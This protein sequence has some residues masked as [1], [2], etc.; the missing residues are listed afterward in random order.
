MQES[1]LLRRWSELPPRRGPVPALSRGRDDAGEPERRVVVLPSLQRGQSCSPSSCFSILGGKADNREPAFTH[2]SNHPHGP[3]R[4]L[5][6]RFPN[7]PMWRGGRTSEGK[8]TPDAGRAGD[9][10]STTCANA[11]RLAPV[12]TEAAFHST[13]ERMTWASTA[14]ISR[15]A[16]ASRGRRTY[17]FVLPRRRKIRP[18]PSRGLLRGAAADRPTLL[19]SLGRVRRVA[20]GEASGIVAGSSLARRCGVWALEAKRRAN[21]PASGRREAHPEAESPDLSGGPCPARGRCAGRPSELREVPP[22]RQLRS[23]SD[24]SSRPA[25]A[26][27]PALASSQARSDAGTLK[28]AFEGRLAR[29]A[30]SRATTSTDLLKAIAKQ[31]FRHSPPR[32]LKG[33]VQEDRGLLEAGPADTRSP[34]EAIPAM[35]RR[36]LS[37]ER[38][39]ARVRYCS[40]CCFASQTNR[41][42]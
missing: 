38:A 4:L 10:L 1:K 9:A 5:P 26:S 11:R 31:T 2:H 20:P 22:P 37:I 7:G 19:C 30:V 41:R 14:L 17:C 40:T 28:K 18:C 16:S 12:A 8:R 15:T 6:T 27:M 23:L 33:A 29:P 36:S 25:S 3:R 24:A 35:S 32:G 39:R 42:G 13:P 34:S 21:S